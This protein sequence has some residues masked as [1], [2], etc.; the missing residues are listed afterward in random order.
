MLSV[1]CII[2][3]FLLAFTVQMVVDVSVSVCP[4][5]CVSQPNLLNYSTETDEIWCVNVFLSVDLNP[6]KNLRPIIIFAKNRIFS[7]I[8][9]NRKS[10]KIIDRLSSNLFFLKVQ[11]IPQISHDLNFRFFCQGKS[12]S[13]S[14][15]RPSDFSRLFSKI[16]N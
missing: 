5:V 12:L 1:I 14:I 3:K 15:N 13:R 6:I 16:L 10:K 2:Y 11:T 7:K 4:C 9:K 8:L